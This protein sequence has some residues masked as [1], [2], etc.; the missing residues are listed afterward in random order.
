MNMSPCKYIV[1]MNKQTQRAFCRIRKPRTP[2]KKSY[3]VFIVTSMTFFQK[4]ADPSPR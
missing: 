1:S 3:T 4:A 2:R